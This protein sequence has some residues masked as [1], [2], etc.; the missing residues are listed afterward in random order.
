MSI[1]ARSRRGGGDGGRGRG[2]K[3]P[4]EEH[5]VGQRDNFHP[6]PPGGVLLCLRLLNSGIFTN[7]GADDNVFAAT[8]AF[9]QLPPPIIQKPAPR[10]IPACCCA[11]INAF[12]GLNSND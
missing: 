8:Q 6:Q 11:E 2:H 1:P 5:S 4:R 12:P 7:T 9:P 3:V 10:I